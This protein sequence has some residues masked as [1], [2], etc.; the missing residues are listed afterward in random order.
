MPVIHVENDEA[1]LNHL[2]HNGIVVVDFT[3][4]WCG[5]CQRI[6]PVFERLSHEYSA[7]GVKFLKVDVDECQDTAR[8]N[9]VTAMP[10]FIF[11]KNRVAINRMQGADPTSLETKLREIV[12]SQEN[13]ATAAAESGVAGFMDLSSFINK[14]QS[15]CLNEC[16]NNNLGHALLPGSGFYLQSDCDEQL[17][18]NLAFNQPV[19]IHSLK[20]TAPASNGPKRIKLFINQPRT[21]DFDQASSMEPIQTIDVAI[22][23]LVKANPIPL[24]FVKFQ[25][26]QNLIMFVENNQSGT[27]CTRIDNITL[28][29]QTVSSTN[30]SEFKRIAGKKGESH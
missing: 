21:L 8:N 20:L 4:S 30:M 10:T 6:A 29:G 7:R 12:N 17:I 14:T 24:R 26:V 23:D 27:D 11:F 22:D 9:N 28:I 2:G 15:E 3:A 1:F 25:N 13:L 19:K 16:D 18:I 5:P